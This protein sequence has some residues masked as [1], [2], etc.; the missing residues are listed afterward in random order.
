MTWMH[1][2]DVLDDVDFDLDYIDWSLTNMV[3]KIHRHNTRID[4]W[5][6]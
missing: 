3:D 6:E 2:S 4:K 5:T 1:L